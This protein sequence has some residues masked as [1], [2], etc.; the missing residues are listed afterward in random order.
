MATAFITGIAGFVGSYL[1]DLLLSRGWRV[2]GID[3]HPSW[4]RDGVDYTQAGVNDTHALTEL[5]RGIAPSQVYHLAGMSFPPDADKSPTQALEI[6]IMGGVSL[7][8]AVR[9]ACPAARVLLVGSSKIYAPVSSG[10]LLTEDSPVAPDS[11]YGISKYVAELIGGQF[12]RQ[13]GLDVRFT[14]SFNHTGPGQSPRLVC[15]DWAR[16]AALIALDRQEPRIMVGDLSVSLDLSDVRDVVAAYCAI[17]ESGQCGATY[18]V[19]SG[20][21][22]T[23][24]YVL[25]HLSAKPG[26]TVDVRTDDTRMRGHTIK[27]PVVGDNSR[28]RQHTG[29]SPAIAFEQTLD[30]LYDWWLETERK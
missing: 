25:D 7:M 6:N 16:Q 12:V 24:R 21:C 27:R 23:L 4:R 3:M 15:S 19:C 17:L 5:L 13:M 18:N 22:I 28:L 10:E 20:R 9:D 1:C 8:E 14:R 29:W 26:R 30:D 11:F 2:A